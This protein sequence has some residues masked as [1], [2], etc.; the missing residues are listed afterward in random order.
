MNLQG[1]EYLAS[2]TPG[3]DKVIVDS[4]PEYI[5][6]PI[7]PYRIKMVRPSAKF[8]LVIRDPTDRYVIYRV[9]YYM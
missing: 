9:A 3:V 8:V 5:V 7:A 1:R 2:V 6:S 4:S